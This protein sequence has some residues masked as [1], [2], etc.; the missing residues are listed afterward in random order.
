M[1]GSG[2]LSRR[3]RQDLKLS[4]TQSDDNVAIRKIE[5]PA[6]VGDGSHDNIEQKIPFQLENQVTALRANEGSF[7]VVRSKSGLR[8]L[9]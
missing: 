9:G 2:F 6:L 7:D 5:R 3:H 4:V 8:R 1:L